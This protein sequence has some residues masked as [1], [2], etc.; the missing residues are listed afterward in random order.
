MCSSDLG[1]ALGHKE[2]LEL[3]EKISGI[4]YVSPVRDVALSLHGL[5]TEK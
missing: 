2:T 1:L 5:D 4:K 3:M